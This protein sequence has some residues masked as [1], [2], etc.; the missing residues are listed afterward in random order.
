MTYYAPLLSVLVTRLLT[1]ILLTGKT[2]VI[3]RDFPNERALHST[4]VPR[5]GGIALMAG[6]LSGWT[7]LMQSL[8]WWIVLPAAGLFA[9]SLLDDMR[10][11]SP[12]TRLIDRK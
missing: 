4:P 3:V 10:N 7:L 8:A 1:F 5:V 11:L 6:V 2:G 9:L 12:Q